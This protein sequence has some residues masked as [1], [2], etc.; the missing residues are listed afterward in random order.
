[1]A[2]R[3]IENLGYWHSEVRT[4]GNSDNI[5]NVVKF[6]LRP[7]DFMPKPYIELAHSI[8]SQTILELTCFIEPN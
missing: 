2:Y 5:G 3:C 1:M 8:L 7:T 6:L 4:V